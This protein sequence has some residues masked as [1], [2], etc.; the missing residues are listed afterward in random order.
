MHLL[1]ANVLITAHNQY[2]P[3]DMVPEFW[4]WLAFMGELGDVKIPIELLEEITDGG[5]KEDLLKDW[6]RV[7]ANKA[8]ILFTEEADAEL[9][10]RVLR[11]GYA[12]DLNDTEI[13]TIGSDPFLIAYALVSPATRCVVTT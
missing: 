6:V 7:E 10:D 4:D 12:P 9:V 3:I 2:Y 13:E 1:D 8:A 11:R 5:P